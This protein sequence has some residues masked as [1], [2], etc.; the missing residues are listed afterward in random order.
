MFIQQEEGGGVDIFTQSISFMLNVLFNYA[1]A[2]SQ[3]LKI[4]SC[5]DAKCVKS[6]SWHF[7]VYFLWYLF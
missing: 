1:I 3:S 2:M 4:A 7:V 6:A 5:Q